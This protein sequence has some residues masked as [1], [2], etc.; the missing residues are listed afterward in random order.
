MTKLYFHTI[1][2]QIQE[3]RFVKVNYES[4]VDWTLATDYL[5]CSPSFHGVERYDCALIHTV[6]KNQVKKYIFVQLLF[7]FQYTVG[8]HT[9]DLAL[10]QPLDAPTGQRSQNDQCLRFTHPRSQSPAS[11]EFIP[12]QSIIHGALIV[13]DFSHANNFLL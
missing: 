1:L 9:L 11:S 8:N 5:R 10:V 4:V 2:E 13:P 6:D 3:Y 12:L 7:I